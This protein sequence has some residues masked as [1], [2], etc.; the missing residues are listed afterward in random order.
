MKTIYF[1][2]PF[3]TWKT[4]KERE[5]TK[6]LESRNYHVINPFIE[7]N[8]LNKKYGVSNYYDSPSKSFIEEIVHNDY[9]LLKKC[10][11][12]FGWFPS[13]KDPIGTTFELC[14]AKMLN[15]N[16]TVLC[17]KPHPFLL[18]FSNKFYLGFEA[19]KKDLPLEIK[20]EE[21]SS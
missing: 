15:K 12:Y 5:I 14:W 10:D 17:Y 8:R 16:I 18:F 13:K 20:I 11:E 4:Q 7:E 19:F 2:H 1:A 9:S 21:N 6:I 3:K